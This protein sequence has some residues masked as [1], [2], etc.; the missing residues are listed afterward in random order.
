MGAE[1][2]GEVLFV[3]LDYEETSNFTACHWKYIARGFLNA[4]QTSIVGRILLVFRIL[5][6]VTNANGAVTYSTQMSSRAYS[7]KA[8]RGK[9]LYIA[10]A[11]IVAVRASL[12]YACNHHRIFDY[13]PVLNR[14]YASVPAPLV[15]EKR[16]CTLDE[17]SKNLAFP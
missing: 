7:R 12:S 8:L 16:V 17:G 3:F 4:V 10:H 11:Y 5:A 2:H 9:F 13:L 6:F 15:R 1:A 14:K